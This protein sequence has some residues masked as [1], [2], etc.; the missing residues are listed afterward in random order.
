MKKSMLCCLLLITLLFPLGARM[1]STNEPLSDDEIAAILYRMS[2]EENEDSAYLVL[3]DDYLEPVTGLDG[4]YRLLIVG[5][6]TDDPRIRGR[7]DTMMLAVL[8]ARNKQLKLISFMRDMYVQIPGH[9]H[10]RMNAAY[11]YGGAEA[12]KNT[13]EKNFHVQADGYIAVNFAMMITLIDAIGGVDIEVEEQEL[14][15]LN[16]ILEYYNYQN[17]KP[18][19]EGRLE[20]AGMQHLSGL[21]AMSYSRIRKIDGDY[22][23]VGRQQRVMMAIFN[24]MK[25]MQSE[26][27]MDIMMQQ[28]DFVATDVTIATAVSMMQ[29]VVAMDTIDTRYL[30]I[31]V[32][33]SSRNTVLN[34]A[35]FIIPNLEK[36]QKAISELNALLKNLF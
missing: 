12:L 9:G 25:N 34:K 20:Q 27:L 1:Q 32:S 31:P 35:Y 17:G 23:R 13:L 14:K 36:N 5:V 22:E 10:N 6:D 18:E 24:R 8:D 21:Q 11:V 15:P 28:I 4:M 19:A 7:S 2:Q 16:G 33:R 26:E 30:R 3:P 29:D